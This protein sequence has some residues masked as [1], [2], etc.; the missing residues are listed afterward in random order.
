MACKGNGNGAKL[1]YWEMEKVFAIREESLIFCAILVPH[2][3]HRCRFHLP[4]EI[5]NFA[6]IICSSL[7]S[8]LGSKFQT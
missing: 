1:G 5:E 4:Y 6:S 8:F 2:K 7:I 3:N